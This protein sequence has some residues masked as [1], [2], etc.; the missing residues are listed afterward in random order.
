MKQV[1]GSIES[2]Y[3][4]LQGLWREIDFH[5]PNPM[6]CGGDIQKYKTLLQEDRVYIFLNELSDGLNKIWSDVL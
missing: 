6:G 2:Y 3:N 4:G 5:C 1:G